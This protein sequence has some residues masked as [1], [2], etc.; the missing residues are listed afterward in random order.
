MRVFVLSGFV[1]NTWSYQKLHCCCC[2]LWT[3]S[4]SW[5]GG[6]AAHF[7]KRGSSPSPAGFLHRNRCL[8]NLEGREGGTSQA[9]AL[10]SRSHPFAPVCTREQVFVVAIAVRGGAA[11]GASGSLPL[12][13]CCQQR[14]L[15]GA[16]G[17]LT[18][19]PS[20]VASIAVLGGPPRPFG[21]PS[22]F[23]VLLREEHGCPA[24]HLW[25]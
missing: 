9:R 25:S 20:T 18:N 17:T 7:C 24:S 4:L 5:T 3:L 23:L 21:G 8:A 14:Q 1:C 2:W 22:H 6:G 11:V 15:R 10:A 19:A 12:P 13:G 16:D